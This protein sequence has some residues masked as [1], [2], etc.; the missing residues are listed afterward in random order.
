MPGEVIGALIGIAGMTI[1][2]LAAI[3]FSYGQMTE[4][5]K[6][7]CDRVGRLEKKVFNGG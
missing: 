1:L 5:L 4:R 6:G 2:N 7:V 3:A